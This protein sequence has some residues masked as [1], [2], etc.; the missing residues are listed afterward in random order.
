M[1]EEVVCGCSCSADG[2]TDCV[3][4]GVPVYAG[5]LGLPLLEGVVLWWSVVW[6]VNAGRLQMGPC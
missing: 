4:A 2:S 6:V 3:K 1:V 5:L